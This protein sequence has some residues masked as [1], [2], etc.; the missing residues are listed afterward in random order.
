M[1]R[2]AFWDHTSPPLGYN[3]P[4][5]L[6]INLLIYIA[7]DRIKNRVLANITVNVPA[8]LI[9]QIQRNSMNKTLAGYFF[10]SVILHHTISL[11][12]AATQP[13]LLNSTA[14]LV[15]KLMSQN[16]VIYGPFIF[17][18]KSRSYR[19]H[20]G[21]ILTC[22]S[23][24][25]IAPIPASTTGTNNSSALPAMRSSTTTR[26]QSEHRRTAVISANNGN[27]PI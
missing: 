20:V 5:R 6:L 24:A 1:G 11:I 26:S 9:A 23:G 27:G 15:L 8:T 18:F 7:I 25:A 16:H 13:S 14:I 10:I 12:A 22:A 21:R 19:A 17:V 3:R 4:Y 2:N